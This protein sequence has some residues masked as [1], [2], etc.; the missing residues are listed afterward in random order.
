MRVWRPGDNLEY[1]SS[2][3]CYLFFFPPSQGVVLEMPKIDID[4]VHQGKLQGPMEPVQG[5]TCAA[6]DKTVGED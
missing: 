2:C 4:D 3:D 1:H 6:V 5:T